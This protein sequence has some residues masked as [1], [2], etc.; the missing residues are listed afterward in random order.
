LDT[1]KAK[2]AQ[3]NNG[4]LDLNNAS[5]GALVDRLRAPAQ[6]AG[7]G[8]SDDQLQKLSQAIMDFRNTPP[9]SGLI[10]WKGSKGPEGEWRSEEQSGVLDESRATG[11]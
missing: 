10:A 6:A 11:F 9:H 1:L 8:L 5:V 2:F 3:P 4:K 7:A